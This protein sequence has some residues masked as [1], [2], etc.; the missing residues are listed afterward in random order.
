MLP[1]ANPSSDPGQDYLIDALTDELTT[2]LARVRDT[3]VIARNTAMTYKG[4]PIDAKAIGKDLSVR[5]C[6]D[7]CGPVRIEEPPRAARKHN[8]Q[9]RCS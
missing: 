8:R 9:G 4:K 2:S 3:F 6:G 7:A 1:F 5:L